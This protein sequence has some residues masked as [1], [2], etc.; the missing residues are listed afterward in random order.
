M[1]C[2][3][4][5][6]IFGTGLLLPVNPTVSIS[7][8]FFPQEQVKHLALKLAPAQ[9]TLITTGQDKM[10]SCWILKHDLP[11]SCKPIA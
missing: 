1:G 8:N 3:K 10:A 2:L 7:S 4:S 6:L 9:R 11:L 5:L